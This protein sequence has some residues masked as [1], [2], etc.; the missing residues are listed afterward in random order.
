MFDSILEEGSKLDIVNVIICVLVALALGFVVSFV[1]MK[2]EKRYTKSMAVTVALIP[3]I[4]CVIMAIVN[5]NLGVGIAV[6]GAFSLIRFR[7]QPGNAKDIVIVF[8]AMALGLASS[9]GYIAFTVIAAVI[10]C[11][12]LFLLSKTSFGSKNEQERMLKITI[13]EDL[14]YENI[15]DDILKKYA[16]EVSLETVKTTNLGSM[17]ELRYRIVLRKDAGVKNMIDEIRVR[18]GNLPITLFKKTPGEDEL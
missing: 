10:L 5:G 7:S 4:V 14:S 3:A 17:Y 8:L 1:Y 2:T 12:V 18:N 9:S 6:M 16:D 15:F 13:S 11:A